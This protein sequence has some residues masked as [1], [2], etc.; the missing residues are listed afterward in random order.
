M[1]CCPFLKYARKSVYFISFLQ[2]NF[3]YLS[4]S[5]PIIKTRLY[6]DTRSPMA[7]ADC[8]F[9]YM[10]KRVSLVSFFRSSF[11]CTSSTNVILLRSA[12]LEM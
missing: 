9:H 4:V 11:F 7:N 6:R 2:C 10:H 1:Y 8:H 12:V 5:A 3:F